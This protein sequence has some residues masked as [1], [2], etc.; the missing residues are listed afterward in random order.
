MDESSNKRK[1]A[2]GVFVLIGVLF[3]IGGILMIGNL[4]ETFK[5]KI[6]LVA[7]FDDVSGLQS[8]NNVWFS[9][10]KIGSVSDLQFYS[11]HTVKVTMNIE[12]KAQPFIRKDAFV[13]VSTDGLIGNKILIIYGGSPQVA[14]ISDL[15]S[16]AVEKS[17]SSEDVINTL[18][19]NN[20]NFLAITNDIKDISAKLSKGEGT[21]GKLLNDEELYNHLNQAAISLQATSSHAQ[22]I[23]NSLSAF[24][25]KLNTKGGLVDQLTTDTTIFNSLRNS[26]TSLQLMS[27]SASAFVN[28]LNKAITSNNSPA[29]VLMND[30]ESAARLQETIKNL[31]SGSKKLD[32]DLEALQHNFLFRGYFKD[33]QSK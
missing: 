13:K 25:E 26:A 1:V 14:Q 9:G 31:E 4:H 7:M 6:T 12:E 30:K 11:Q 33:K 16:L 20:K 18:Q 29:G 22:Q 19:Q 23:T 27:D 10:V 21:V 28:N 8:G 5:K 15:D 2:V 32:E 3:L 24:S 17:L